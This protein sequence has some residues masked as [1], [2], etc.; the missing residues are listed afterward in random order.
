[1]KNYEIKI[2]ELFF[3]ENI[4]LF[5]SKRKF[6]RPEWNQFVFNWF[7]SK[8]FQVPGKIKV[9]SIVDRMSRKH[10]LF[11]I[12]SHLQYFNG[13]YVHFNLFSEH[14]NR[15]FI[16]VFGS[17]KSPKAIEKKKERRETKKM[18]KHFGL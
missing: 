18:L 16:D 9:S 2:I 1:M 17:N 12:T 4:E 14:A 3:D 6:T 5:K 7:T 11:F 13:Q 15:P 10:K 8:G